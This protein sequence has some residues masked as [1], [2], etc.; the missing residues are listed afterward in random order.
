MRR[1][2]GDF[3]LYVFIGC[4]AFGIFYSAFS[5]ILGGHDGGSDHSGD[6]GHDID[7]GQGVDI[8][9]DIDLGHAGF[10]HG[11]DIGHD[12][13]SGNV[14]DIVNGAELS[15]AADL[16]QGADV[17][18]GADSADSP[19]PFNP[20]VLASAITAF[21]AFGLISMKGFGLDGLMST[22]V[23]LGFAGAI[24]AAIFFGIVKFMYGSQS[25]TIFSLDDLIGYEAE[26]IT[27]VPETGLGEIA[28][29]FN[30]TRRTISARSIDGTGIG[31]GATVIIRGI[32]ANVAN[33]QR[34]LTL[35]DIETTH[36]ELIETKRDT[37]RRD[38]GNN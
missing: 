1:R 31:R 30:G 26:I 6:I 4:F 9:H 37:P 27:P 35:D 20:L 24:G 8:G 23:A 28:Y 32:S 36:D 25:N 13:V 29:Y 17:H 7:L 19:S 2:G 3:L 12:V 10:D 18:N 21:G 38:A 5:L 34:K 14:G 16:E 15:H 22:I 11:I 33:V